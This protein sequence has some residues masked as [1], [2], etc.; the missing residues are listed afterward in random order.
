[1]SDWTEFAVV[2]GGATA[3]LL[4]VELVALAVT[5]AAV[6]VLL[7]RRAGDV[8]G[9]AVAHVLDTTNPTWVTCVLLL[10]SGIVLILGHRDGLYVLVPAV[11][12]VLVGGVVNAWL[13]L[14]KLGE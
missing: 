2:A 11:I 12:A 5:A 6:A 10:A 7:D 13:I 4:G 8:S 1:V 14:T 9:S 3:A